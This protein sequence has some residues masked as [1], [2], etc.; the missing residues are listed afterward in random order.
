MDARDFTRRLK[1]IKAELLALKQAHEYGLNR[2]DFYYSSKEVPTSSD[3]FVD[4]KIS[5]T[6]NMTEVEMPYYIV[7]SNL[8]DPASTYGPGLWDSRNKRIVITGR[9]L[10]VQ[11]YNSKYFVY[12]AS[13]REI[14]SITIEEIQQ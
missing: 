8:D 1:K 5:I 12:I 10:I 11:P 4:I 2:T 13:T 6:F 14:T 9:T 3:G 7:R